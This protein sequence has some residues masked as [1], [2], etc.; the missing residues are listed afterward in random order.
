M[1]NVVV[2]VLPNMARCQDVIEAWERFGVPGITVMESIGLHRLKQAF[3]RRDDVP[4]IPSLRHLVET[5]EYHHRTIFT[6]VGDDFDLDGLL[7]ATE[8]A[9]HDFDAP[10]SGIVFVVPVARV[11]GLRS[12]RSHDRG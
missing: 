1:P 3:A 6:V 5:E 4:L 8:A 9:V 7:A 12:H 10:D 11:L 2:A